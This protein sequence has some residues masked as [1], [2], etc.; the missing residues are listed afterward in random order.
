M[1]ASDRVDAYRRYA[2]RHMKMCHRAAVMHEVMER[3]ADTHLTQTRR[4]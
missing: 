1:T 2:R 4:H 3:A